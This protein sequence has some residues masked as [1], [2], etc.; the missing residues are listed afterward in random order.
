MWTPEA[1][2]KKLALNGSVSI[3]ILHAT[4]SNDS[5]PREI[6]PAGASQF[7]WTFHQYRAKIDGRTTKI[8]IFDEKLTAEIDGDGHKHKLMDLSINI[9]V[10]RLFWP[11]WGAKLTTIHYAL[12]STKISQI[13]DSDSA[14]THACILGAVSQQGFFTFY[15]VRLRYGG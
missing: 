2:D 14:S 6:V 3:T 1:V 15:I 12:T 11:N 8:D 7:S 10:G 4:K 9:S 13:T 5:L